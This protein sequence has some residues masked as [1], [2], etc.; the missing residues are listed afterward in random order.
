MLLTDPADKNNILLK[1]ETYEFESEAEIILN[2][3]LVNGADESLYEKE[4][5]RDKWGYYLKRA[6]LENDYEIIAGRQYQNREEFDT[7]F[8]KTI[9]LLAEYSQEENF[10]LVE[11]ILLRPRLPARSRTSKTQS[12]LEADAVDFLSVSYVSDQTDTAQETP[13]K[14]LYKFKI[15]T[16]NDPEQKNKMIWRLA[17]INAEHQEVLAIP[18]DFLLYKHLTRRIAQIRQLAADQS[19]FDVEQNANGYFIFSVTE[20][21]R[22]LAL[23]KKDY[24][25]REDLDA[26]ITQ[27]VIFFS[28]EGE[29]YEAQEESY[30][31]IS[32]LAD[33]YSLQLS[34]M[35]PDWPAKFRNQTFKHLLEKTIYLE[36]PAHIYP[37]VYWLNHRQM[38]DFEEAYK[39]WLEE[40]A[41]TE[42]PNTEIVNNLVAQLNALRK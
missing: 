19:N 26:E 5:R 12:F 42:I 40:L 36:T 27:L 30:D 34:I 38:R 9:A 23:S 3:M 8:K 29:K 39:L 11:H 37:H 7:A 16:V 20:G 2:Y 1:S 25:L 15:S 21:E 22:A 33:P 32:Y 4:E 10:H 17:L 41:N 6:T 28:Y 14:V 31:D 35:I 18:E 13:E 24:R